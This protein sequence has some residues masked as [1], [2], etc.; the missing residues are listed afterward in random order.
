M[1]FIQ[2][3]QFCEAWK[4]TVKNKLKTISLLSDYVTMVA[5]AFINFNIKWLLQESLAPIW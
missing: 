2:I 1:Q 5:N 4:Y 3:L